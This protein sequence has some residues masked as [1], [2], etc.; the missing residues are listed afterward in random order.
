VRGWLVRWVKSLGR[1]VDD[2]G[3]SSADRGHRAA[4]RAV[5]DGGCAV[6]ICAVGDLMGIGG[7][8]SEE[9]G[10]RLARCATVHGE[11]AVRGSLASCYVGSH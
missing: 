10:V 6:V 4:W 11:S 7:G 2:V 8:I 5:V 3:G 9:G 1:Y